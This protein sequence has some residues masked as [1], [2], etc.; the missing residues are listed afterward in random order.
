MPPPSASAANTAS[1]DARSSAKL[2]LFQLAIATP[3]IMSLADQAIVSGASFLMTVAVGRLSNPI[4]LGFYS[5]GM[6]LL[7]TMA[8]VQIALISLPYTIDSGRAGQNEV[9][10][11]GGALAQSLLLS[12]V[13]AAILALAAAVLSWMDVIE[14]AAI[15]WLALAVPF[16]LLREF[17]RQHAFG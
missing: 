3:H 15:A 11:L 16:T 5:V 1:L 2:N 8:S 17:P 14:G 4:E 12:G 10:R 9:E 13:F 6:S 7:M